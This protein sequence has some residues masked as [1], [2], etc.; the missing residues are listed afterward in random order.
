MMVNIL[1]I[2]RERVRKKYEKPKEEPKG[3]F[4]CSQCQLRFNSEKE[5]KKHRKQYHS[6]KFGQ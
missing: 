4:F 5:L 3:E 6:Y 1:Q 2:V